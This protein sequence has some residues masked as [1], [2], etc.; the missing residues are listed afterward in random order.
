MHLQVSCSSSVHR[1][2]YGPGQTPP[3]LPLPPPSLQGGASAPRE[4]EAWQPVKLFGPRMP[5]LQQLQPVLPR[6]Q[7]AQGRPPVL[8]VRVLVVLKQRVSRS[9]ASLLDQLATPA[10]SLGRRAA[11]GGDGSLAGGSSR[12]QLHGPIREAVL[13][14]L[15]ALQQQQRQQLQDPVSTGVLGVGSQTLLLAAVDAVFVGAVVVAVLC[16]AL[17]AVDVA[18]HGW[19][20][21]SASQQLCAEEQR[22][23]QAPLLVVAADEV[24]AWAAAAHKQ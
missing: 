16:A 13:A 6:G 19:R 4:E 2:R 8:R 14:Q 3:L 17:L 10:Q 24:A 12:V 18:R 15:L 1:M 7:E 11:A 20:R 22:A 23:L 5:A 9:Q 21:R